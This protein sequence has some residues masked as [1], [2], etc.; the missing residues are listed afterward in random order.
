MSM[1][2]I[3]M[4]TPAQPLPYVD[5]NDPE[6]VGALEIPAGPDGSGT[7][8]FRATTSTLDWYRILLF[9]LGIW[10]GAKLLK[11]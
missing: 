8:I 3:S 9:A 7:P 1:I 11:K 5:I 10:I 2:G 4:G 6:N